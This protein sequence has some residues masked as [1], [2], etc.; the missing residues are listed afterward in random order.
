MQDTFQNNIHC[1]TYIFDFMA[2]ILRIFLVF[3]FSYHTYAQK[4]VVL[5]NAQDAG[6]P[7]IS[8]LK[9]CC[10]KL[11]I[12]GKKNLVSSLGVVSSFGTYL[13]DA[14]PDFPEQVHMLC[15]ASLPTGIFLTHAH[16]GHYTGLMYLGREGKGANK[17]PVYVMPKMQTF[18]EKNGP[19]NQLV[20][21]ENIQLKALRHG[22]TLELDSE[23]KVVTM[24]V[25]HRDEFSETVGFV[26]LG[27]SK[28]ALFLPDIDKWNKWNVS[29]P[30]I[31]SK[32]DYAFID[33]TFF[34]ASEIN[35]NLEEIPHPLV[36]E[37][38]EILKELPI[39]QK[40]KV[41]FI[42]MNHTNPM[43]E[44]NSNETHI[45]EGKGFQIAR[46]NSTFFLN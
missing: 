25:P 16:I 29:L 24:L 9:S 42:H 5:G 45:V 17:V 26:L 36:T 19:W 39:Q 6:S 44:E 40:S 20:Q 13:L 46:L 35:R 23:L 31:I 30:E 8:C 14:T 1:F 10:E 37:T 38:M 33:G 18:L 3:F 12:S 34:Q 7:H 27:K 32:V 41:V 2:L 15:G 11:R 4:I 22:D 28:S 21:L 43:L